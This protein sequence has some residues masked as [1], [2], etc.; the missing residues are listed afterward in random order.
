MIQRYMKT[1]AF[2]LAAALILP[3]G[4]YASTPE[5]DVQDV[6]QHLPTLKPITYQAATEKYHIAV[7]IDNQCGYCADVLKNV[8]SYTDAG[9]TMSFL[10]AAPRS[11]RDS[12]IGDMS[13]VWCASDQKK[14]LQNAMKGFLPENDSTP[15]CVHL[16]EEQSALS[17]RLGVQATPAML[18]LKNPPVVFLGNIK[19]Q[20]ILKTLSGH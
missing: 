6:I 11:I 1:T 16:I 15:E 19:P 4:V 17:D 8:K 7:F 18:V 14:S 20:D 2:F 13:R 5:E 9:L 3:V 10:T 12:V